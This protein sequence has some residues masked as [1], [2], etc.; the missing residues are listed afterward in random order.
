MMM[1]LSV[2]H[3]AASIEGTWTGEFDWGTL[4]GMP[5]PGQGPVDIE[6]NT[7]TILVKRAPDSPN[8]SCEINGLGK[9]AVKGEIDTVYE[10]TFSLAKEISGEGALET[11][12]TWEYFIYWRNPPPCMPPITNPMLGPTG[13]ADMKA[14][15]L[16][17][18]TKDWLP[19]SNASFA[20]RRQ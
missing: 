11:M 4:P 8:Y 1:G 2:G 15:V 14:G 7:I 3:A 12:R 17:G 6:A 9:C 10:V 13:Q 18:N 16:K 20:A 5:Q 19:G